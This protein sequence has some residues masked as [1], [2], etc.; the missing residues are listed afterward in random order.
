MARLLVVDDEPEI[1][2][3]FESVLAQG[4]C[5]VRTCTNGT[6]ALDLFRKERTDLLFCDLKLPGLSGMAVL[7]AVK[8]IDPGVTVIMV[9][10][11]SSV[12]TV[13]HAMRLGAYDFLQKPFTLSQLQQVTHRALDHRRQLREI[14]S[15]QGK[16]GIPGDITSRL[17]EKE[18]S[19]SDCLELILQELRAPL[20]MLSEDLTLAQD[21]FY[22]SWSEPQQK[23]LNRCRKVQ[24]MLLRLLLGSFAIF[25]SD[26]QQVSALPVDLGRVIARILQEE[27]QDRCEERRLTLQANLPA[28]PLVGVTDIEKVASIVR[29]LLDNAIRSTPPGG[30]IEVELSAQGSKGFQL[31][32]RDTGC[33]IPEEKKG[34]L[35]SAFRRPEPG[36]P[37]PWKKIC[38]GLALVR[39]YV[40][41]LNGSV[42]FESA[43]GKGSEF[44]VN[45]PFL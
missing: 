27:I 11:Y 12:E 16:P 19:K 20:K 29:E 21:G 4:G 41:L 6:Q 22:G 33:G 2:E 36:F 17:I 9:T 28:D 10:A 32:V 24:A 8:S 25:T 18:Q 42:D 15:L 3:A 40:D 38:F 30:R 31:R 23:L 39:Y 43:P 14:A 7:E 13:L 44:K 26:Q 35:F 5:T 34:W 1:C 37:N 45:C